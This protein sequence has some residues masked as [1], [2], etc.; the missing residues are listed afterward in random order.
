MQKGKSDDVKAILGEYFIDGM[1]ED[2]ILTNKDVSK[3][4]T[5][6]DETFLKPKDLK[7]LP[8]HLRRPGINDANSKQIMQQINELKLKGQ[9]DPNL[10]QKLQAEQL[11]GVIR[12]R[13][14]RYPN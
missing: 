10:L 12:D 14:N 1:D 13:T 6:R 11:G 4:V 2:E 7:K 8:K 9:L 3:S 5:P